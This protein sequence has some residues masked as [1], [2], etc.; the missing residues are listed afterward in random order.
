MSDN[1]FSL[2]CLRLTPRWV[3]P[4]VSLF[5]TLKENGDAYYFNPHQVTEKEI[6]ELAERSGRDLYYLLVGRERIFGYGLLRGW[7]EDYEVPSL[8]IV[9]DP[10]VRG[11]GLGVFLMHFLHAVA[12][13]RGSKKV[14]LRVHIENE[15]AVR[16]YK[17]LGYNFESVKSA[18]QYLVGY[19]QLTNV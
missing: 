3:K 10:S 12:L 9:I 11:N 7:D 1:E 5:Q 4:L 8:G 16:F 13:Q 14:R 17:K 2:E 6:S 18:D 15:R 19:K